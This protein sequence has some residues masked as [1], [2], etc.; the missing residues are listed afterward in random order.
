MRFV[1]GDPLPALPLMPGGKWW[2][3]V[4]RRARV[5]AEAAP[6]GGGVHQYSERFQHLSALGD[7]PRSGWQ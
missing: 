7:P 4:V 5:A 2:A 6:C 1:G 3:V